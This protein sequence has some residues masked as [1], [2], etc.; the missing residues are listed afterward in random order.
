VNR[1][2][3]T[4]GRGAGTV[5]RHHGATAHISCLSQG[6][7]PRPRGRLGAPLSGMRK[8]TKCRPN[9][10]EGAVGKP[11]GHA[12]APAST[13]PGRPGGCRNRWAQ[14]WGRGTH[15]PLASWAIP[16]VAAPTERSANGGGGGPLGLCPV[17][18]HPM[19]RAGMVHPPTP[20]LQRAGGCDSATLTAAVEGER[21]RGTSRSV[22]GLGVYKNVTRPQRFLSR[23]DC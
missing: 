22:A 20:F 23:H 6:S 12:E 21:S 3:P 7:N 2:F 15:L 19:S 1:R 17:C 14:G 4:K 10:P 18:R 16:N 11:G 5:S 13:G 8:P 9:N